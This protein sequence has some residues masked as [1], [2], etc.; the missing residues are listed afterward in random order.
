MGNLRRASYTG[1]IAPPGYPNTVDTPSPTRV[2][3]TISAPVSRVGVVK[4][5][6][7]DCAFALLPMV[8][9]LVD[10]S[11]FT[12]HPALFL[13]CCPLR[14]ACYPIYILTEHAR[15]PA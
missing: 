9:S 15:R 6:S 1:R 11:L 3:H 7:A 8:L 13:R 10:S 2:A 4:W 5:L 12:N 14:C